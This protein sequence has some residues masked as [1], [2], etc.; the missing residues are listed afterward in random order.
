MGAL[1]DMGAMKDMGAFSL[2]EVAKGWHAER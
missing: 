1:K 2:V